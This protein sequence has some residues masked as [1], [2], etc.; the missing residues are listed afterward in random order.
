M[1]TFPFML[2]AVDEFIYEKKKGVLGLAVFAASFI[3][4][5]FFAGQAVFIFIYWLMRMYTGSFRM[6]VKEFMRF[7]VEVLLGFFA[8]SVI[9]F[10]SI[11]AV[12]QNDRIRSS[13]SGWSALV[14]TSE[15]R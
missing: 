1:V 9:L 5:Y 15:Q 7:A 3:N 2:A 4:Y 14:Y 8:S 6:S 13:F 12:I 10:P 11:L